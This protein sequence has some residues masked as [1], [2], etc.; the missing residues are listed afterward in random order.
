M[1]EWIFTIT[2]RPLTR[3]CRASNS[4]SESKVPQVTF[5][6]ND[7]WQAPIHP[8]IYS[9]G[10]ICASI[11]GNDWSPVL[12]AVSICITMQSML[13]SNKSKVRPEGDQRYVRNAPANPK[14][15]S[16][17]YDDDVCTNYICWN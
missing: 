12:N 15:T 3:P 7:I 17:K 9:N 5:V 16:W 10:H 8:H 11:L 6:V 13:A 4:L 2:C 14:L 1:E